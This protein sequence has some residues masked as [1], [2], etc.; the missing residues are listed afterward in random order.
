VRYVFKMRLDEI[1]TSSG[2]CCAGKGSQGYAASAANQSRSS[3]APL[4]MRKGEPV[5]KKMSASSTKKASQL[6]RFAIGAAITPRVQSIFSRLSLAASILLL[7]LSAINAQ[8]QTGFAVSGQAVLPSGLPAANARV[9]VCPYTA[10]GVPCAPQ[11]NIYS[12]INL[13]VLLTQPYSSDQYGNYNFYVTPGTTYLVQVQV[14]LSVT[15]HYTVTTTLSGSTSYPGVTSAGTGGLEG[16]PG[17]GQTWEIA[18]NGDYTLAGAPSGSYLKA[19]GTGY[20]TP[21][22]GLP[23]N[24]PT[25]TGTMTGGVYGQVV[26]NPVYLSAAPFTNSSPADWIEVLWNGQG[27]AVPYSGQQ[28]SNQNAQWNQGGHNLGQPIGPQGWTENFPHYVDYVNRS[29]A[30]F[31]NEFGYRY[32]FGVGDAEP[33]QYSVWTDKGG[34]PDPSGEGFYIASAYEGGEDNQACTTTIQTGGGGSQATTLRTNAATDCNEPFAGT[35]PAIGDGHPMLDITDPIASGTIASYVP[36]SGLTPEFYTMTVTGGSITPST[37]WGT[38]NGNCTPTNNLNGPQTQTV[39]C[40][41]TLTSGTFS[42][43]GLVSFGGQFHE[44]ARITSVGAPSG[45][46]QT[47]T[48]PIRHGHQAGSWMMQG[49]PQGY[50]VFTANI[51]DGLK[52]PITVLGATSSTTIVVAPFAGGELGSSHIGP[53]ANG[54]SQ[55]AIIYTGGEVLD[56]QNNSP[57]TSITLTGSV[58]QITMA[59]TLVAGQT[60]CFPAITGGAAANLSQQCLPVLSSGLSTSGFEVT[61]TGAA[62]GPYAQSGVILYAVDGTITIEPNNG[63]WP[64]AG[65]AEEEHSPEARHALMRISGTVHNP[66]NITA[67]AYSGL[68]GLSLNLVGAGVA[69]VDGFGQDFSSNAICGCFIALENDEPTTNYLGY[70]GFQNPPHFIR[71]FGLAVG[72]FEMQVAPTGGMF[73]EGCPVDSS[74]SAPPGPQDC[75]KAGFTNYLWQLQGN[76]AVDNGYN[77]V[78]WSPSTL[79]LNHQGRETFSNPNSSWLG[80]INSPSG[81][82]GVYASGIFSNLI[83]N[84]G[85]F[86]AGTWSTGGFTITPNTTDVTDPYGG[87][88]ATKLVGTSMSCPSG[89]L[90][91][92]TLGTTIAANTSTQVCLWID[93]PNGVTGNIFIASSNVPIPSSTTNWVFSCGT[94]NTGATSAT[95]VVMNTTPGTLYIAGYNIAL[96]ATPSAGYDLTGASDDPTP[97][98]GYSPNFP[99]VS[100]APT[101]GHCADFLSANSIQDAGIPCGGL[102]YTSPTV[103]F[104]PKVSNTTAPGTVVNSLL[105]DGAT[106]AN[107]LTYA[108]SGGFALTGTSH[109]ITIPAG[110]AVAPASGKV[111]ISSDPTVGN[112]LVS[113]NGG[114]AIDPVPLVASLVTTAATSDNV[115][116]T[117]MTSTGHCVLQPTNAAASTATGTYVSAKT[118]NQITVT[119]AVTANMDFDVICTSY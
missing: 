86:T 34:V 101:A 85:N 75:A 71:G 43:G 44:Q 94:E 50:V 60:V 100:G 76:P 69:A 28:V 87:Q 73:F 110:T 104:I 7:S 30:Q 63:F 92:G 49:G 109:G 57:V 91:Q 16:N 116:L 97:H 84:S 46:S 80:G 38:L 9:T 12:D 21:S 42:N 51:G 47:I 41:V 31:H 1:F 119:H 27:L 48:L 13:T 107:T 118:T 102:T 54:G 103:G 74:S 53:L 83:L 105:D 17:S 99:V 39:T 79:V 78:T 77:Q 40:T 10:S 3:T 14:N 37:A 24:N 117:G 115:T 88:T 58:A 4:S 98:Y 52:Y 68:S 8:A 61:F 6:I 18:P 108:G 65:I 111:V 106:T 15:Y 35:D 11:A 72:A 2:K 82:M 81:S 59:N 93:N 96:G 112:L 19:D 22:S 62:G 23:V 64:N 55:V 33:G 56:V 26:S 25:F 66:G 29:Q 89:C 90:L 5:G 32:Q 95:I 113:Q 20:G 45:G 70:T 67:G 114:I 36:V